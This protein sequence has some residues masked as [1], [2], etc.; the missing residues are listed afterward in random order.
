[1]TKHIQIRKGVRSDGN[2]DPDDVIQTKNHLKSLGYYKE[3]EY[4]ITPYP[5]NLL[6]DAIKDYQ[7]EKNLKVDGKILPNGETEK[8]LNKDISKQDVAA[9]SPTFWCEECNGPHGGMKSSNVCITCLT[10]KENEEKFT[11]EEDED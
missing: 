6:I 9:R 7:G 2:S 8:A 1:M 4:G 5:D 11:N 10:R 3:P